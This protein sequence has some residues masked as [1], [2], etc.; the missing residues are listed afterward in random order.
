MKQSDRKVKIYYPNTVGP[1]KRGR[2]KGS[3]LKL[4]AEKLY[5]DPNG[6]RTYVN[7][8]WPINP[9]TGGIL[10]TEDLRALVEIIEN[11]EKHYITDQLQEIWSDNST[12]T[13]PDTMIFARFARQHL[14]SRNNKEN[15]VQTPVSSPLSCLECHSSPSKGPLDGFIKIEGKLF[16]F[17]PIRP[18]SDF[19][20]PFN[21]QPGFIEYAEY[22]QKRVDLGEITQ[23]YRDAI[24]KGL[25]DSTNMENP[26]IVP[27]LRENQDIPW[28]EGDREKNGENS[29]GFEYDKDGKI[30]VREIFRRFGNE[31]N[32]NTWW[33]RNDLQMIP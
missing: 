15:V 14:Y 2:D 1:K 12:G 23:K 22:L 10:P 5:I 32:I 11:G 19:E 25:Q 33:R 8:H 29:A 6:L 13:Y 24:F 21:E 9:E 17:G 26:Y 31:L 20:K 30:Y 4:H 18:D 7:E 28:L 27:V 16:N 3:E